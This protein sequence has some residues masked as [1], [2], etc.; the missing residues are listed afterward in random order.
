M[1]HGKTVQRIPVGAGEALD[2]EWPRTRDGVEL[3]GLTSTVEPGQWLDAT[4]R[5]AH[6]RP[7]TMQI[8]VAPLASRIHPRSAGS[9]SDPGHPR[10][11]SSITAAAAVPEA[12][13]ARREQ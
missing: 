8:T 11:P 3:V 7:V 10:R 1:L 2:L 9:S 4:F 12:H 6:S 13:P 5:F